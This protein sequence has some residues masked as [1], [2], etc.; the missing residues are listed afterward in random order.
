MDSADLAP[1]QSLNLLESRSTGHEERLTR[2]MNAQ[3]PCAKP[4]GDRSLADVVT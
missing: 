2:R 4:S 1:E 3:P